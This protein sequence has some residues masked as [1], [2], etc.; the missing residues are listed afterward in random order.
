MVIIGLGAAALLYPVKKIFFSMTGLDDYLQGANHLLHGR[1]VRATTAVLFGL[2]KLSFSVGSVYL[3]TKP[4][5]NQFYGSASKPSNIQQFKPHAN[6]KYIS[7]VLFYESYERGSNAA[8]IAEFCR[9]YFNPY[10]VTYYDIA[11]HCVEPFI[12]RGEDGLSRWIL[13]NPTLASDQIAYTADYVKLNNIEP[14]QECSK[15]NVDTNRTFDPKKKLFYKPLIN[16]TQCEKDRIDYLRFI[17]EEHSESKALQLAHQGC[18]L[19]WQQHPCQK[20]FEK[21]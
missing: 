4:F 18:E 14:M 6:T 20:R 21:L 9:N 2:T 1:F 16:K 15:N 5:L 7:R 13:E 17:L 11:K 10:P 19:F 8:K 3:A 12:K